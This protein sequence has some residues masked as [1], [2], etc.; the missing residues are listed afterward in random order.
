MGQGRDARWSPAAKKMCK[1]ALCIAALAVVPGTALATALG[2]MPVSQMGATLRLPQAPAPTAANAN[3]PDS[4]S[5]LA[6][7]P[8]LKLT[9]LEGRADKLRAGQTQPAA[10]GLVLKPGDALNLAADARALIA[11]DVGVRLQLSGATDLS[12]ET[13][14][15]A[16][17]PAMPAILSLRSGHLHIVLPQS[18]VLKPDSAP[19]Y[20]YAAGKRLRLQP[21]EYFLRAA[22]DQL[23]LCVVVGQAASRSIHGARRNVVAAG[24]CLTAKGPQVARL[25]FDAEQQEQATSRFSA[26][27]MVASKG[28]PAQLEPPRATP[29]P[30]QAPATAVAASQPDTLAGDWVINVASY[31]DKTAAK[32]QRQRLSAAGHSTAVAPAEVNGQRWYRV[33]LIGFDSRDEAMARVASLK[34][35]GMAGRQLW[36]QRR[37]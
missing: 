14:A 34:Q 6:L 30:E 29:P 37:P 16:A 1:L 2:Q 20:I 26:F 10:A 25:S 18:A 21:G 8:G 5:G 13:E 15:S 3:G 36:V 7:G 9:E 4:A 27:G 22:N 28:A 11:N 35:G 12:V 31:T 17:H 19:L 32:L 23:H 33:E 24:E